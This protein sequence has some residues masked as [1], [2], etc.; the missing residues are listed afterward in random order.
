MSKSQQTFKKKER[1]KKKQKKLQDKIERK[2][3]RKIEKAE[4]GK[5]TQEE[6]FSYLD[7]NGNIVSEKPDPANKI[8][9]K[10]ENIVLGA[11]PGL[12]REEVAKRQGVVK[13]F[14]HEKA[15]GFIIDDISKQNV[16]VHINECYKEIDE[17][18]RV[19]YDTERGPKGDQA[20]DVKQIK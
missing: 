20:I 1:E 15:F 9:I 8:E 12:L 5:L 11:S 4:K 17:G 19:E 3:Q 18:H 6:Q 2:E 14:N 7:H 10:L 16:F 13:F